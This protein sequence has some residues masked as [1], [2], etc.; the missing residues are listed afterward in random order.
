MAARVLLVD[1]EE[2]IR[3]VLSIFLTDSGYDV[4]TA[5]DGEEALEFFTK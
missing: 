3:N 2:G 1:D 5:K 4:L